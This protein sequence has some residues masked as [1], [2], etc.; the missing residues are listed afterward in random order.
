M[1]RICILLFTHMIHEARWIYI[2][3]WK[4]SRVPV[5]LNKTMFQWN[6]V[7]VFVHEHLL[8]VYVYKIHFRPWWYSKKIEC[9]Q[10]RCYLLFALILLKLY[11]VHRYIYIHQTNI[12]TYLYLYSTFEV[13][14]SPDCFNSVA[15][16]F[17]IGPLT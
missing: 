15:I 11:S 1:L 9:G 14:F 4:H 12:W 7:C 17:K 2:R 8:Y 13:I 10:C 3:I 6:F 16:L 5:F